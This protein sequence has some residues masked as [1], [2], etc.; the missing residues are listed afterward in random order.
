MII[1]GERFICVVALLLGDG[2]GANED[3]G[4]DEA[5]AFGLTFVSNGRGGLGGNGRQM[6]PIA[7][8]NKPCR[9]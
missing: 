3:G 6:R 1:D 4:G 8:M 7:S 2:G 9:P 5:L